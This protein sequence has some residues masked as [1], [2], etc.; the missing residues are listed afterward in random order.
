MFWLIGS[1]VDE[2]DKADVN[3]SVANR[4]RERIEERHERGIP[5]ADDLW[6]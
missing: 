5:Q 6:A 4:Y 3:K 1:Q 2:G